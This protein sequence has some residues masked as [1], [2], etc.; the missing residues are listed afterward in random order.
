MSLLKKN[1]TKT[2]P[3]KERIEAIWAECDAEIDARTDALMPQMV[4]VPWAVVRADLTRHETNPITAYLAIL[5]R[6]QA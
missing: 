1:Q 3:L 5:E 2:E 4:G 6:E